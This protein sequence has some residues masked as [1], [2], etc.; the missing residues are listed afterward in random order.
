MTPVQRIV[1]WTNEINKPVWWRHAVRLGLMH[2]ELSNNAFELL[3][4]IAQMQVGLVEKNAIYSE[5]SKSVSS[6]GFEAEESTVTL[7]SIGPVT[8]VSSL[9]EDQVLPF[10]TNGMTVVY[11]DNGAGKSSYSRILKHT[12]LTRGDVPHVAGNVFNDNSISPSASISILVNGEEKEPI[13]WVRNCGPIPELKSIRVFDSH[14]A[15]HYVSKEGAI[16]YK[17]AG[18][19]LLDDLIDTCKYVKNEV[20]QD[21]FE[22]STPIV[23]PT[24]HPETNAGKF[25]AQINY[26]TKKSEVEQH[27]I[28]E[29]ESSQLEILREQYVSYKSKT[30]AQL[31]KELAS[32]QKR[33][34]PLHDQLKSFI[35]IFGDQAVENLEALYL[36][37]KEKSHAAEVLRENTLSDLPL[38]DIGGDLWKT[39]WKAAESFIIQKNSQYEFPPEEGGVCPLCLQNVEQQSVQRLERFHNYIKDKAQQHADTAEKLYRQK[40]KNIKRNTFDVEIYMAALDE[41]DEIQDGA[42]SSILKLIDDLLSRKSLL[43]DENPQFDNAAIDISSY[44]W[45]SE[46]VEELSEKIAAVKDDEQLAEMM[47]KLLLQIHEIEDRKAISD[48]KANYLNE[49]IRQRKIKL[50]MKIG[51]AASTYQI[52]RL[53]TEINQD[54][55][56]GSIE[57]AFKKELQALRF[58]FYDVGVKTRGSSGSQLF[59][60]RL[61]NANTTNIMDIASEGEQKCLALASFLAEIH[62]DNRRSSVIFDDPVSSLDHKWRRKFAY[63][64]AKESEVRQV[65]VFTHDLTFLKMLEEATDSQANIKALSRQG[66]SSG[67]LLD[68]P[69]WDALSTDRRI[70][71]LKNKLPELQKLS[72]NGTQDEYAEK[73]KSFYGKKR[74]TWE[75]LVEEWLIRG[76]IERFGRGVGTQK[77]RYLTDI[78]GTDNETI[79]QGM[80]KCSTFFDGHDTASELGI[81][82]PDPEE[83]TGD[84]DTLEAYFFGL[85]QRRNKQ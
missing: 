38:N 35:K 16:E 46:Q 66:K 83:I 10:E 3:Y 39:M 80:D 40:S 74:E 53:S 31:R 19:Q 28:S 55:V 23:L 37:Y 41:I 75:R 14:A 70:K 30:A 15:S 8:N 48:N 7:C 68:R 49:I 69:P 26:R 84:L 67:Y 58:N 51:E 27:Y 85:K 59:K 25:A 4:K 36:D 21:L 29:D 9:L 34:T 6:A 52:T 62:A 54:T 50:F 47:G 73:V 77:I 76:V 79:K 17:P 57:E 33:I 71:H 78:T 1:N 82:I 11:G 18:L 61:D 2:G 81:E 22:L 64:L 65:I 63:R 12:C 43:I 20:K 32:K 5:Y 24:L 72:N 42:K 60:I 45:L 44:E 13:S 56:T